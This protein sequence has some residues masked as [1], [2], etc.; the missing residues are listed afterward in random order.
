MLIGPLLLLSDRR[1]RSVLA[2]TMRRHFLP[3]FSNSPRIFELTEGSVQHDPADPILNFIFDYYHFKNKQLLQW[4]PGLN[5]VLLGAD[6]ARRGCPLPLKGW[7]PLPADATNNDDGGGSSGG[8]GGGAGWLPKGDDDGTA[9]RYEAILAGPKRYVAAQWVRNFL[10]TTSAR[11]PALN[12]FGLHEWAMLYDEGGGGQSRHQALP[13]RV[14]QAE[15]NA[16]IESGRLA[17]THFDAFRFFANDARPLNPLALTRE[18]QAELDQPGCLHTGMDLLKWAL[19]LWPF[20]PSETLSACLTHSID[21][22]VLDMRASPYD[23]S[24][25]IERRR[26]APAA[27]K[28]PALLKEGAATAPASAV[29][30]L[31]ATSTEAAAMEAEWTIEAAVAAAATASKPMAGRDR[32]LSPV[33]IETAEGRRQYQQIQMSLYYRSLPLRRLLIRDYNTF[34]EEYKAAEKSTIHHD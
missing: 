27:V 11:P 26:T 21:C 33:K 14:S 20:L 25:W 15:L 12:C 16:V 6:P 13:L 1:H 8:G 30:A 4:S 7:R 17:C 24:P 23:L 2:L 5:A 9:G 32:D 28:K 3:I 34:L 29:A 19:K 18:R 22:R 10:D 31:A